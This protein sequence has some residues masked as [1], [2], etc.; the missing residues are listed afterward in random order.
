MSEILHESLGRGE[1]NVS[2]AL[3]Q[4]LKEQPVRGQ[5]ILIKPNMVDPSK[6]NACSDPDHLQIVIDLLNRYGAGRILVGDEP[7]AHIVEDGKFDIFS[8]YRQIGYARLKGA[9]LI[10][11]NKL[12]TTSFKATR[13]NPATGEQ[14]NT[15]I[16]VRNTSGMVTVSFTL[17]KEHGNYNFSGVSKNLVGLVPAKDRMS[18]F[19]YSFSDAVLKDDPNMSDEDFKEKMG[20]MVVSFMAKYAK[21][22][23]AGPVIRQHNNKKMDWLS[24]ECHLEH[25]VNA[26]A[27]TGL[28]AHFKRTNPY[29]M[30]ILD[31]TNLLTKQEHD[32]IPV[33]KNF[34]I[35]GSNPTHVDWLAMGILG[36][37]PAEVPYLSQME[38][39]DRLPALIME[40][41]KQSKHGQS[42]IPKEQS[43]TADGTSYFLRIK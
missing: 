11:L 7:A 19:H 37:N 1:L 21:N 22:D 18:N 35:A 36:V 29:G 34:A 30:Y 4:L 10:D 32:G 33:Y 9:E 15:V 6:P 3:E 24:L 14:E 8:A 23:L 13:I 42:L 41:I 27:L 26:G 17:P 16:P 43:F 2:Y 31:G 20:L 5:T 39:N 25:M 38:G 28:V 12:E 40:R